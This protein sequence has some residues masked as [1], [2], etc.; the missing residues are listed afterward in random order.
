MQASS[1]SIDPKDKSI[2]TEK[3]L[4]WYQ[5]NQRPLPWKGIKNP[6]F[7]W[8]SEIILQQTRV[9]QGLPYYLRFTERYPT[10]IDLAQA[11][12]D[13]VLKLWEGLGYYSRARNLH[14]AA[15][16]VAEEYNG[17][18]PDTYEGIRSL[19]GVGEY[20]AAA[21]AS[22]A[23]GLPYAV[24]DG[25]VYRVL[26]R[27]FGI[28]TPIDTTPGKKIFRQLADELLNKAQPARYNQ[29]IMDFGAT[30]CM[31]K[32]PLCAACLHRPH[33]KAY[34]NQ[35][36]SQLPVKSKKL[37][38]RHRYFYYWVVTDGTQVALRKR[39]EGDIWAGLYDFPLSELEAWV[40]GLFLTDRLMETPF[41]AEQLAPY[42]PRIE[43]LSERYDQVLTHQKINA[44]FIRVQVQPDFFVEN[45]DLLPVERK[46]IKNFAFPKLIGRYWA[47]EKRWLERD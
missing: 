44:L 40:E 15:K 2:F 46:K 24:V 7:I 20:T 38:K 19:K 3:L 36:V 22:F 13:E 33:C 31:P 21:I 43:H 6:Y 32:L 28:D 23:Y 1:Q 5:P 27:F 12:E 10:I 37:K 39:A 35:Q 47:Q 17:V 4:A 34:Q 8:L 14:A 29:A 45:A 18:F 41:W 30:H 42:A 9:E 11:P 25:N 16:M 26:A